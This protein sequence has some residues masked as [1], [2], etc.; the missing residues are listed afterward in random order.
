MVWL[1]G[2]EV[3]MR[4][5][6][7]FW[8]LLFGVESRFIWM[9]WFRNLWSLVLFVIWCGV[10]KC[11]NFVGNGDWGLVLFR[12]IFGCRDLLIIVDDGVFFVVLWRVSF[13]IYFIYYLCSIVFGF[14]WNWCWFGFLL[15]WFFLWVMEFRCISF[16]I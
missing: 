3:V 2:C 13:V 10:K 14:F 4:R 12:W 5:G 9:E 7:W 8:D 6:C 11:I 1:L 16:V 15:C